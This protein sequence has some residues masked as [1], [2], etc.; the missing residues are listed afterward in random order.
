ME[1]RIALLHTWLYNNRVIDQNV[2]RCI[3][4]NH[5]T[6]NIFFGE[7]KGVVALLNL[8]MLYRELK[9]VAIKFCQ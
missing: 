4:E 1:I 2:R 9:G 8:L 7:S 5:P 6:T 3:C